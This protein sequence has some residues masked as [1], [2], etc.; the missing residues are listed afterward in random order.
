M[1]ARRGIDSWRGLTEGSSG[2][3]AIRRYRPAREDW[4]DTSWNPT[5]G[6]SGVSPG[7]HN[8]WAMRVAGQLA[9][10]GGATAA[11]YTGLTR[12]E[13]AGPVWTGVIRV[14]DDLL[15]WPLYRRQPR[16][17]AV[18]LMSDLFHEA[19]TTATIDLVHAVIAVAH[20]HTFLVLTKRSQRMRDYYSDPQTPCRIAEEIDRW[21]SESSPNGGSPAV[22]ARG[23]A[24]PTILTSIRS[25]GRARTVSTPPHWIVGFS[26]VRYATPGATSSAVRPVGLEPWPLPNLWPGVSV[27]D[28]SRIGR[29]GDLL[30][31][32]AAMRWVCFEPL[33]D[34]VMPEA[35]P[36]GDGY[37]DCL[38]GRHYA[39]DG[40]GRVV[41]I[42][43]PRWPPLDW[44]VAGG[45]IGVGARPVQPDWLRALR[46]QCFAAR[47]PFF[48]RQWGEWAPGS[49]EEP[50][51]TL[52]RVGKRAAG[53]LLDG[54]SWDQIPEAVPSD[55]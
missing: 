28:Q 1:S 25:T 11:R 48:F 49:G 22:S 45:E 40:R 19:L 50:T 5:A 14:R 10:M 20:W 24:V 27:E 26:R 17:I 13:R 4:Y 52:V 44:V 46:D 2:A 34:R 3:A 42:E 21:A 18:S 8:C 55:E 31:M 36:A 39:I 15:T 35:I 41:A 43:G 29:I 33:L 51:R 12:M 6:C 38:A 16:R 37:F 53:R 32:P 47:V 7:C 9:R 23:T 30:K 54:R